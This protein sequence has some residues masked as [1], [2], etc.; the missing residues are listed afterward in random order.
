MKK[1]V[2]L[3]AV[4]A[5]L[6]AALALAACHNS[7]DSGYYQSYLTAVATTAT[8]RTNTGTTTTTTTTTTPTT[9]TTNSGSTYSG[10]TCYLSIHNYSDDAGHYIYKVV[11]QDAKNKNYTILSKDYL[12]IKSSKDSVITS[13]EFSFKTNA[14]CK[15]N[16][17]KVT[18]YAKGGKKGSGSASKTIS[19]SSTKISNVSLHWSGYTLY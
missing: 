1:F 17:L 2:K 19:P 3:A 11:V 10:K 6:A 5:A 9:V 14:N 13:K 15:T 7:D 18:V 16:S 12:K 4:F 8:T